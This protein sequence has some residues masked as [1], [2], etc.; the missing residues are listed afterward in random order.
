[1]YGHKRGN[2]FVSAALPGPQTLIYA[3]ILIAGLLCAAR[4]QGAP[5]SLTPVT[6]PATLQAENFDLG[7]EGV[8]YHDT[9]AG[10]AGGQYRASEDVDIF[11]SNDPAGGGF[12][13]KNFEAGEWLGYTIDVPASG[14]YDIEIRAV[15]NPAFPNSAYHL[16]VDGVNVSGSIV[17][18][19]TD[20]TGWSNFQWLGRKTV[21]LAAGTH[22]LKV[23]SEKPYFGL[24]AIRVSETP[25]PVPYSGTPIA[26][27]ATWEAE[28]FDLGGEGVAYHDRTSGNAG[29]QYRLKEDVDIIVSGASANG[30]YVVN[31][32]DTDEWLAYTVNVPASAQ[33]DIEIRASTTFSNSAF[34]IEIDGKDVTGSILVPNTGSWSVF[35]WTGKK[36]VPLAAGRHV[37]KIVADQ[38]YF[39]LNSLRV[40]TAADTQAPSIP[41]NPAATAVSSSQIDLSW[42]AATDNVGAS[43]YHVYRNAVKVASTSGTGYSDTGLSAATTYSYTIAA[44]DAAGNVSAQSTAVGAITQAQP[45]L[46]T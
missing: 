21:Q 2:G 27:P 18:P 19:T 28:N 43:G 3:L 26:L 24:N 45:T 17:L 44:Y 25:P 9:T 15:T 1:M 40:G 33:Y 7:G 14:S 34:H 22:V 20:M 31:N 46:P 13:I 10:N 6:V 29:G 39:S 5:F 38:Q 4:A 23:V 41:A 11:V 36:D 16:E 42:S 35:R 32:F 12:I 8:A 37:L 30:G